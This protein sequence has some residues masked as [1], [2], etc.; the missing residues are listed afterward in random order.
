MSGNDAYDQ[1]P[2]RLDMDQELRSAVQMAH[3]INQDMVDVDIPPVIPED[4]P[5]PVIV[6]PNTP[7]QKPVEPPCTINKIFSSIN[8]EKLKEAVLL[9]S[10][11]ALVLLSPKVIN[12][13]EWLKPFLGLPSSLSSVVFKGACVVLLFYIAKAAKPFF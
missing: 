3:R 11:V 1:P 8:K 7:L 9:F 13:P 4:N 6:E 5:D 12:R 10:V 2:S